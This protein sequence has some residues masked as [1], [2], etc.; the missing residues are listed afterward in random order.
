M[1]YYLDLQVGL[2]EASYSDQGFVNPLPHQIYASS[3]MSSHF[4][5]V[6]SSKT[7]LQD[8]TTYPELLWKDNNCQDSEEFVVNVLENGLRIRSCR[9]CNYSSPKI[10]HVKRHMLTHSKEKPFFCDYCPYRS[11]QNSA[12]KAHMTRMHS[13]GVEQ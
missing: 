6:S 2:T 13:H 12:V 3:V 5:S 11:A 1:D 7:T 10:S 8:A 9:L 4:S